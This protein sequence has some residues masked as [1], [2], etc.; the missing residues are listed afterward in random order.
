M[1]YAFQRALE[2]RGGE[3]ALNTHVQELLYAK[4]LRAGCAPPAFYVV[5]WGALRYARPAAGGQSPSP[6]GP[7]RDS[8]AT[9]RV[10]LA[11]R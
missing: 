7:A 1:A 6:P 2:T 10:L 3:L 5:L 11:S 4:V 9:S 8:A